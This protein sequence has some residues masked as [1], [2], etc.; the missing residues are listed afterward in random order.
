MRM[1]RLLY[2]GSRVVEVGSD[3]SRGDFRWDEQEG[4]VL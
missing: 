4:F 3:G 1:L 2:K